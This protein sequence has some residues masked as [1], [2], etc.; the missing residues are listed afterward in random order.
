MFDR[1]EL[2]AER[3]CLLEALVEHAAEAGRA[4]GW[5]PPETAGCCPRRDSASLRS[6]SAMRRRAG[7]ASA[8][9]PGR[10]ARSSGGRASLRGFPPAAQAPG[11]PATAS[12]LLIVSLW[13]SMSL[14]PP[15]GGSGRGTARLPA[16]TACGSADL[17]A[18]LALELLHAPPHAA[19]L[20][21][22]SEDVSTPA[23]LRPT[24]WSA[25]GPA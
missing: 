13:K 6:A 23:R 8:A 3:L 5:A 24:R 4:C 19:E 12:P 17:V 11:P 15:P 14:A 10:A 22:E 16:G 7:R 9:A 1:Y 18:Q 21:L 25:A 20:V 2:V